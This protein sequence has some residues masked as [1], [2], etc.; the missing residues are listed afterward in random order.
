MSSTFTPTP[1]KVVPGK[2]CGECTLCCKLLKI[3]VLNKPKGRWCEHCLPGKGCKIY[4]ERPDECRR[5]HCG[6]LT[7]EYLGDEWKPSH[8]KIVLVAEL[9]GNRIAAYVDP[10]R[11]DAWKREPY[12]SQLKEWSVAAAQNRSQVMVCIGDRMYVILPDRDED[13]GMVGPDDVIITG[14]KP[15]PFGVQLM[16][17]KI[18][19]DDPRLETMKNSPGSKIL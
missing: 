5:F 8:S 13:L 14:E 15:T 3:E 18:H 7:L 1:A 2:S 12:Y 16:A 11:P 6:Y 10:Q 9:E 4:S 17:F 19:K